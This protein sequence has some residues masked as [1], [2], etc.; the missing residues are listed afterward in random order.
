[1]WSMWIVL[2]KVAIWFVSILSFFS[3]LEGLHRTKSHD[4]KERSG[5][6]VYIGAAIYFVLL[7]M[8]ITYGAL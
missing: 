7:A 8:L 1:M 5:A 3:V 6:L 4:E 2:I